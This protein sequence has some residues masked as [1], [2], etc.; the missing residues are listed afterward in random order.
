MLTQT[1]QLLQLIEKFN[2]QI[3]ENTYD[4]ETSTKAMIQNLTVKLKNLDESD[5]NTTPGLI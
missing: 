4:I 1:N 2:K 3:T 5:P